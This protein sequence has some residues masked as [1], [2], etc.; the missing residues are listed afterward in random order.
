MDTSQLVRLI[1]AALNSVKGI[2]TQVF[3]ILDGAAPEHVG[4]AFYLRHRDRIFLISAA[5]VFDDA[6]LNERWVFDA[7]GILQLIKGRCWKHIAG[8]RR[9]DDISDLI[10][11]E[12]TELSNSA[13]WNSAALDMSQA[14]R[15]GLYAF[16]GF[17]RTKNGRVYKQGQFKY[18]PYSHWDK[19]IKA[20]AVTSFTYDDAVNVLIQYQ[21]KRVV[22]GHS[23]FAQ[24]GPLM[25]GIS[26]GPVFWLGPL[27]NLSTW[28][29]RRIQLAGVVI[30]TVELHQYMAGVRIKL[31]IDLIDGSSSQLN[32][33][34]LLNL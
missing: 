6:P 19:S 32:E 16:V 24:R 10:V 30:H 25:K 26:G 13:A 9:D 12:V 17:P 3:R 18:R 4:S 31:A 20:K 14:F 15:S 5:H 27:R 29:L 7:T 11:V 23:K 34:E 2:T 33:F 28:N 8:G 21:P 22:P 1:N